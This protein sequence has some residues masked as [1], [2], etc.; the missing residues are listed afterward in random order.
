M[1]VWGGGK[2]E[3]W[4]RE[5]IEL[6]ELFEDDVFFNKKLFILISHN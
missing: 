5:S 4:G 1:C 3:D 6:M 2:G